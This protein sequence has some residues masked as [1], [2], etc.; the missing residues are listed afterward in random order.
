MKDTTNTAT[1]VKDT[2]EDKFSSAKV[3]ENVI[4]TASGKD[5]KLNLRCI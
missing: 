5:T 1:D 2:S 3:V 4:A